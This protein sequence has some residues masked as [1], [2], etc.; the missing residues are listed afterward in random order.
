[1]PREAPPTTPTK[2]APA[3]QPASSRTSQGYAISSVAT[4]GMVPQS[5]RKE[6]DYG[7]WRRGAEAAR[8]GAVSPSAGGGAGH[9]RGVVHRRHF[10]VGHQEHREEEER[11][12]H[13]ESDRC[14]LHAGAVSGRRARTM[15]RSS[16]GLM[17]FSS[18]RAPRR[19][20][21]ACV[22]GRDS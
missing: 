19:S 21:S 2:T 10:R 5:A 13:T 4:D 14:A 18:R 8:E 3:T 12:E 20:A 11:H 6:E 9:D 17:G 15:V 22:W 7:A 16:R 1:T